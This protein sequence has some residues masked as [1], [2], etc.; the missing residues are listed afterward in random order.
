MSPVVLAVCRPTTLVM[1]DAGA[2][3]EGLLSPAEKER[4]SRLRR[5]SDR[6]DFQAAHVLVRQCAARLLGVDPGD[7]S[8]V[9]HCATC[10]GPHGRPEVAGHPDVGASIAHSHGVV[11]AAAGT[12]PVGIDVEAFPPADGLAATDLS[13][14][15]TAAEMRAIESAADRP[16]AMLLAWVRKEACLKAG[17]VDLDGL[18]GFDL[19]GLR[20]D[21]PPVDFVVRSLGHGSWTV[22]DWRDGRSGAIGAVVAPAGAELRL[23][24]D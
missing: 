23:T 3:G 11:A 12:V 1:V 19:S 7:V 18:N 10:G 13:A 21:P 24:S 14:A 2:S 17:L 8:I 22:H 6:E 9:Q 15:L 4:M 5:S 16:R 20:L